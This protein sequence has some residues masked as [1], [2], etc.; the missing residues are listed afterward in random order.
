MIPFKFEDSD[1]ILYITEDEGLVS[2]IDLTKKNLVESDIDEFEILTTQDVTYVLGLENYIERDGVTY[3]WWDENDTQSKSEYL[4]LFPE[5][6]LLSKL[7]GNCIDRVVEFLLTCNTYIKLLAHLLEY[8]S[9]IEIGDQRTIGQFRVTTR[10]SIIHSISF[11]IEDCICRIG[12]KSWIE[13]ENTPNDGKSL[14]LEFTNDIESYNI[15]KSVI[16]KHVKLWVLESLSKGKST[17]QILDLFT[18]IATRNPE[19]SPL[20]CVCI[21]GYPQ[22]V[23]KNKWKQ[24][25][26]TIKYCGQ[27][28]YLICD[29]T[30]FDAY[31]EIDKAIVISDIT[32]DQ[33]ELLRKISTKSIIPHIYEIVSTLI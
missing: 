14:R 30:E 20:I 23:E 27:S 28:M 11:P 1:I 9:I 10:S 4:T 8:E 17:Q 5:Y 16:G 12:S 15:L 32:S 26:N 24:I 2:Y 18:I 3:N 31:K 21:L 6:N 19:P 7:L 25:V 33:L 13:Y 29:D 22:L